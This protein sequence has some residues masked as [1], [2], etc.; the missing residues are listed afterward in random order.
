M[1]F[2]NFLRSWPLWV[3]IFFIPLAVFLVQ[4]KVAGESSRFLKGLPFTVDFFSV[5]KIFILLLCALGALAML[6]AEFRREQ[7]F[8][9]K[10]LWPLFAFLF[11]LLLSALT[12]VHPWPVLCFGLLELWDGSLVW[13]GCT[14]LALLAFSRSSNN[15]N[16]CDILVKTLAISF[17]P[18]FLIGV[19]QYFGYKLLEETWFQ[20]LFSLVS[21]I[22]FKLSSGE[23]WITSTLYNPNI[24][25]SYV[26]ILAPIAVACFVLAHTN[27][28]R[29]W[30]WIWVSSL[31]VMGVGSQSRAGFLGTT[32][33][34][35]FLIIALSLKN[36]ISKPKITALL[37]ACIPASL[38]LLSP[39]HH[40]RDDFVFLGPQGWMKNMLAQKKTVRDLKVEGDRFILDE[41]DCSLALRPNRSQKIGWEVL[42]AQMQPIPHF[43]NTA[44][45]SLEIK[46]MEQP[47]AE[48]KISIFNNGSTPIARVFDG[49]GSVDAAFPAVGAR[50]AI[51]GS[52]LKPREAKVGWSF[53]SDEFASYRG[54]IWKRTWPLVLNHPWLGNGQGAFP[55]VFPQDDLVGKMRTLG[56]GMLIDKPHSLYLGVAFALGFPALIIL[57]LWWGY[58]VL[59][60]GI[61]FWNTPSDFE[62]S[63]FS[64][65]LP[66]AAGITGYLV[67]GIFNDSNVTVAPLFWIITGALSG[68]LS[69]SQKSAVS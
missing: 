40:I 17:I 9:H 6:L 55:A 29:I 44:D 52:L 16:F 33:G 8:R 66:F 5:S 56:T 59:S 24:V 11:L 3:A 20:Q 14:I 34:V 43:L 61:R 15:Q 60:A 26:A 63:S 42:N 65:L 54:Y 41:G 31:F 1:S 49:A 46:L 47:C 23:G 13:V 69:L 21:N 25:G 57:M 32:V 22:E 18:I 48:W 58:L 53:L 50:V 36:Q 38:M 39:T 37:L 28:A 19:A 64:Y 10:I 4:V 7:I 2:R 27:H 51:L 67:A 35:S 45:S 62:D 68:G 30:S 12:S